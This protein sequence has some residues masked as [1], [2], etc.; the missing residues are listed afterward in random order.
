MSLQLK[1]CLQNWL[2]PLNVCPLVLFFQISDHFWQSYPSPPVS[3]YCV[4]S[5]GSFWLSMYHSQAMHFDFSFPKVWVDT[6]WDK[7]WEENKGEGHLMWWR[8]L[9]WGGKVKWEQRKKKSLFFFLPSFRFHFSVSPGSRSPVYLMLLSRFLNF[10]V[11]NWFFISITAALKSFTRAVLLTRQWDTVMVLELFYRG[12]PGVSS[13]AVI[14]GVERVKPMYS[15]NAF[16][17]FH[18]GSCL[19]TVV[20]EANLFSCSTIL[21]FF[22]TVKFFFYFAILLISLSA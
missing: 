4:F 5:L 2:S 6:W 15:L 8:F 18:W 13:W 11:W 17:P 12:A 3:Q 16:M 1:S 14:A 22:F 20:K 10:P 7:K 19:F 21:C 9:I